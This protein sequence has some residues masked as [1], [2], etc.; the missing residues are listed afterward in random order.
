MNTFVAVAAA[1]GA[2]LGTALAELV[3]EEIRGRLDRIPEGLLRLARRRLP[4]DM[5]VPLHDEEWYPELQEVL[6]GEDARP[7][8]RLVT[9]VRFSLGLIRT[10]NVVASIRNRRVTLQAEHD[11]W[12]AL[13]DMLRF[14][15][16]ACVLITGLAL[17]AAAGVLVGLLVPQ[18]LSITPALGAVL[19]WALTVAFG[20]IVGLALTLVLA[21]G[22]RGT[23]RKM[24]L[25]RAPVVRAPE[26]RREPLRARL[27][28]LLLGRDRDNAH[29]MRTAAFLGSYTGVGLG[30]VMG[31]R[32]TTLWQPLLLT[33]ITITALMVLRFS[34]VSAPRWWLKRLRRRLED[35]A[36][37]PP[38]EGRE[39][40]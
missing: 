25:L 16:N 23:T 13:A 14:P 24:L 12:V 34:L 26:Q 9:G 20:T 27:M 22:L 1:I 33:A 39:Q 40:I 7:I 3:S 37:A 4:E 15:A 18:I 30:A 8:T 2:I 32:L 21:N 36:G 5:R 19:T 29:G 28:N 35:D 10:A 11:R 38:D 6:K 31:E 17:S